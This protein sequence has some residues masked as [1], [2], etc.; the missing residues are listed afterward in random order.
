MIRNYIIGRTS[1]YPQIGDVIDAMIKAVDGDPSELV[2][3]K[4][5]RAEIKA[6][7]PKP[8]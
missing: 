3:I 2:A 8:R 4:A 1:E 7:Y 6:K 5:K